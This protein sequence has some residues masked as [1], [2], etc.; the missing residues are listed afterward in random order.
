VKSGKLTA[1]TDAPLTAKLNSIK[2]EIET[3]FKQNRENGTRGLT[4]DQIQT[5][6]QELAANNAA[7]PQ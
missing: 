7:I 5:V 2:E 6:N 1:G 3:D 4:D